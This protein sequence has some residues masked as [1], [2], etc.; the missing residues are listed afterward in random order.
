MNL[1]RKVYD[2]YEAKT[3][4]CQGQRAHPAAAL[5]RSIAGVREPDLLDPQNG[6]PYAARA[7]LAPSWACRRKSAAA[8][9]SDLRTNA[10]PTNAVGNRDTNPPD[11]FRRRRFS[12]EF[13]DVVRAWPR[14]Q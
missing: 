3:A 14:R 7:V 6:M 10:A 9:A 8:D 1:A 11:Q 4:D 13:S 12:G 5:R 2:H